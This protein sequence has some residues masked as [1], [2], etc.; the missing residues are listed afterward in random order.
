MVE[1]GPGTRLV[2]V[3][4]GES[5]A[6]VGRIVGGPTG[7]NGLS[8]L[9]RRQ[10]EALRE[11]WAA[12]PPAADVLLASTLPRARETA[13]I[14]APALDLPVKTDADLQEM[15]PGE[16]DGSTW[17]D[18]T[19]RYGVDVTAHPY[20]PLSP[21]G[22]SLAAFLL[23]VG[24]TLHRLVRDHSGETLVIA[25]HGGIIDGSLSI[26]LGLP[27]QQVSSFTLRTVNSSITEWVA[28]GDSDRRL[29]WHLVR[30]NDAAH[31]EGLP[32]DG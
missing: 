4:H 32:E 18:Y 24:T 30:Y 11:R 29:R 17:D 7:C 25:C 1:E 26:F 15:Q 6:Q 14:L 22:E 27:T 3:R 12:H 9:G 5:E 8:P 21:G 10:V 13:E 23:R 28:T 19:D 20:A 16:A 2:L 31:L